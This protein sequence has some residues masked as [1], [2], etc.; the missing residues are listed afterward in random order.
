[1]PIADDVSIHPTAIVSPESTIGRGCTIGP[2]SIIE[3]Q[4]RMGSNCTVGAY[5]RIVSQVTMGDGN[6]V[7]SNVVLGDTPQHFSYKGQPTE[8]LIG[9]GNTFRENVTIHRG[10]HV[11]GVTK[12]G[13]ECYFMVGSHVAHDCQVGNKVVMAN[14]A[15]LAGHVRVNDNVFISGFSG[16]HQFCR[17][18]RGVMV[19][20]LTALT[21]DA[22]PF[23]TIGGR[24]LVVGAN[25]VGLRRNGFS[26]TDIQAVRTAY[27]II[28]RQDLILA[29]ALIKLESEL[30]S[31]PLVQEIIEFCRTTKRGICRGA[32]DENNEHAD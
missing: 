20:G 32:T 1:M 27:K 23:S 2:F 10:S 3:A 16:V 31:H 24:N 15:V 9:S 22:P 11:E 19:T 7:Y 18:G 12:I 4:V 26:R 5:S 8:L 17:I 25:L 29:E 13:D 14:S 6:Y 28:Y 21:Q 30:G